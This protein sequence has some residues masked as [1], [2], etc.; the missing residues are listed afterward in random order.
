MYR[1]PSGLDKHKYIGEGR[2]KRE[3]FLVNCCSFSIN[4]YEILPRPN[5][6]FVQLQF[7]CAGR[8]LFSK[9]STIVVAAV[10]TCKMNFQKSTFLVMS[11]VSD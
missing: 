1:L 11:S 3:I 4:F 10:V 8:F 6:G 7:F 5:I 2:D 9:I